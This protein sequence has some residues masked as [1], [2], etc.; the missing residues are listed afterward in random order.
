MPRISN[1]NIEILELAVHQLD[2]LVERLVLLG[3]CATGLLLTDSAA[4]PIRAT[5]DVDVITEVATRAEY[6]KM[7]EILRSKGFQEDSG[8][9]APVCR[10]RSESVIL[11]VMPTDHNI[12][13]FGSPWYQE[14]LDNSTTQELPSGNPKLSPSWGRTKSSY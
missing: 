12:F 1:P 9:D 13:G 3:G 5:I 8:E 7:A 4:P 11:D 2:D 10:W 14:A 6:Y